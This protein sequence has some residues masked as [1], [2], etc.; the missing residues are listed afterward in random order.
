MT[1]IGKGI[2]IANTV[3]S[4]LFLG[5]ATLAFTAKVELDEEQS[6]LRAVLTP[7]KQNLDAITKQAKD[8]EDSKGIVLDVKL[9]DLKDKRDKAAQA[10]ETNYK[11]LERELKQVR[12]DNQDLQGKRSDAQKNL[13]QNRETVRKYEG[14]I[15][16]L[17][18]KSDQMAKRKFDIENRLAQ[19]TNLLGVLTDRGNELARRAKE[20]EGAPKSSTGNP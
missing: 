9:K 16:S 11:D 17:Q 3:L 2:V 6:R 15:Q 18:N 10:A 5:I 14:E 4:F 20:L 12:S 8:I 7:I 1:K 13:T 19:Q